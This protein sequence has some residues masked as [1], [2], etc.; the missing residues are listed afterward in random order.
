M[1]PPSSLFVFFGAAQAPVS[2]RLLHVLCSAADFQ[3][4]D[5][6]SSHKP[7]L[8]TQQMDI[9]IVSITSLGNLTKM[10]SFS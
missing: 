4:R 1:S 10:L 5:P 3:L 8:L 6:E 2:L 9:E 7:L